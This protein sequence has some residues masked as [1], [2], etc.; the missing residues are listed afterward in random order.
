MCYLRADKHRCKIK[1]APTFDLDLIQSHNLLPSR[2][3][4][5]AQ[6]EVSVKDPEKMNIISSISNPA[7]VDRYPSSGLVSRASAPF[8]QES[9]IATRR[10]RLRNSITIL[11]MYHSRNYV[12]P[13]PKLSLF[14]MSPL[15]LQL[16]RNA[17][18]SHSC[19][20]VVGN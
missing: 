9:E 1:C 17:S 4:T 13:C 19:S 12:F 11:L 16:C 2:T 18:A 20:R 3:I 8:S 10:P 7:T 14:Q 5:L 15:R 6:C